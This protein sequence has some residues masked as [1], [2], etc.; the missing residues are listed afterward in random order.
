MPLKVFVNGERLFAEDLNDNFAQVGTGP[1]A[2]GGGP[3]EVFYEND[4]FVTTDYEITSGKNAMTAGPITIQSGITV[5]VP[6]G[7]EWT[8]V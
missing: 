3:D 8:V 5:T 6:S 4:K 7:S 1:G 2:T